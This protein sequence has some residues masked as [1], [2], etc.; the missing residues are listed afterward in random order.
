MDLYRA[1]DVP[2]HIISYCNGPVNTFQ[3]L[4]THQLLC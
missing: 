1:T 4:T 3:H 2:I